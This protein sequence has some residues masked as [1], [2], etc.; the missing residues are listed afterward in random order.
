MHAWTFKCEHCEAHKHLWT[1]PICP[2]NACM[3]IQVWK[4]LINSC[5]HSS[6]VIW[7]HAWT[8][9][10]EH[11][12]AHE[13]LW[14]LPTCSLNACMYIQVWKLQHDDSMHCS[15]RL[16]FTSL[17]TWFLMFSCTVLI[18]WFRLLFS[19][20]PKPHTSQ[21]RFLILKSTCLM[22]ISNLWLMCVSNIWFHALLEHDES[23]HPSE[24]LH[25]NS[26]QTWF[27]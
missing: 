20:A 17:Q 9:K 24:R 21:T 19:E 26:L 23:M 11:Y 16:Y 22:C 5:G 1:L 12:Q 27:F 8:F 14:T 6:H 2:L 4:L 3:Y 13:Q 18:W 7:M 10:C 25:I 15:E